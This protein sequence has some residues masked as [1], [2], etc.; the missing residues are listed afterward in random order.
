MSQEHLE[1][2]WESLE[3]QGC[4]E[5]PPDGFEALPAIPAGRYTDRGFLR[6]EKERLW[7]RSWLYGCH[8]DQLPEPGSFIRWDKSDSPIVIVRCNDRRIR[9]FYNVCRHR[10]AP[11]V[12][13]GYG[14]VKGGFSCPFHGWKYD[15]E[16]H[17]VGVR[18]RENFGDLDFGCHNLKELSCESIGKWVFLNEDSDAE[19]L[20]EYL[21]PIADQWRQFGPDKIRHVASS[22]HVVECNCK[23]MLEAFLEV[24]HLRT[25]HTDTAGRFLDYRASRNIL[26]D[27]GHSLMLTPNRDPEWVDPGTKGMRRFAAIGDFADR[28]NVSYNVYPNLVTPVAP[29]GIPFLLFWPLSDTSTQV[30]CH[31]FA[32]DWGEGERHELWDVRIR[33]FE[34]ILAEDLEMAPHLQKSACSAAFSG[35]HL[36]FPERRI[37]HWHEELDRRIG[38]DEIPPSLSV[39][40]RMNEYVVGRS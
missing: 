7:A 25:V 8:A 12:K 22:S 14:R 33:N 1:R 15:L 37:Y 34:R 4:H 2:I 10:G 35:S 30:D 28:V 24:Y 40:P 17:L 6:L 31:W 19:P 16:G 39:T 3:P 29:T 9:A 36:S 21:G 11:L 18:D 5:A 26:W 20:L 38:G 13:A 23:M 32:P 27:N